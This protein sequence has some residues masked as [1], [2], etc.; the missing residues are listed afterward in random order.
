MSP[1][2]AT[3]AAPASPEASM[4]EADG[5]FWPAVDVN[6]LRATVRLGDTTLPHQR[7][8][9][10]IEGAIIG[11]MDDLATWQQ[12]QE[13]A[14]FA[15]LEEVAD[16]RTVN[17]VAITV[18]LWVRAVTYLAAAE[19]AD[20]NADLTATAEGVTRSQDKRVIA[21]DFRRMAAAALR[22]LLRHGATEPDVGGPARS[23]SVLVDL[24]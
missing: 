22:G 12:R 14:G 13:A 18:A 20:G 15:T 6:A 1:F 5:A 11:A 23:G 24:V 16:G 10:A 19:L 21:D 17:G 9:A 4:V 3:P 2:V 8:V 7:L